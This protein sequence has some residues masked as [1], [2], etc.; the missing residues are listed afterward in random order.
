MYID[1]SAGSILFQVLIGV[2]LAIPIFVKI[3]WG[4]I[5][6]WFKRNK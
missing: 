3:Y 2:A 1:P 5:K 4:K 6:K